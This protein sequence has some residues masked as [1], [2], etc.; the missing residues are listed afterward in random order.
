VGLHLNGEFVLED[1]RVH[2][3]QCS[4]LT[5][6]YVTVPGWY[7][8]T[9]WYVEKHSASLPRLLWRKP[10][11]STDSDMAIVSGHTLRHVP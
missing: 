7:P 3:D 6:V 2:A 8:V 9:I 10:G 11:A 5:N 1:P 4:E